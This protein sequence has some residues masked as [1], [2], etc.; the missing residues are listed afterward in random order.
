MAIMKN[1][2]AN[3]VR[4][5]KETEISVQ[6]DL[7]GTGLSRIST[8]IP[9]LN[10]MLELLAKH[11]CIDLKIRA[12]GD[13]DV[14]YHH[15]VED[16]GL[17][18]GEAFDRALGNRTGIYRYGWSVLPMDDALARVAVDLGGRPY[19]VYEVSTKRK[20]I[21]DFDV[22]LIKEFFRAFTTQARMN[23]HVRLMYGDEP[24]HAF[25]AVFKAV[26]RA[27][28]M[29]TESDPRARGVPSSKGLL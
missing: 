9:F 7:D 24:H 18:L 14:D 16:L 26:A 19:L 11:S 25:E 20:R 10:H 1:R 4:K 22:G 21:R 13:L 8:G 3:V 29:A 15:T 5:T 23:L 6:L 28:R 2:T 12:K 17:V 27:L